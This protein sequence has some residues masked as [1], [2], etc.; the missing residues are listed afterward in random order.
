[1]SKNAH[2]NTTE[3]HRKIGKKNLAR[4][5]MKNVAKYISSVFGIRL[6]RKTIDATCFNKRRCFK[7]FERKCWNLSLPEEVTHMG[8][9]KYTFLFKKKLYKNN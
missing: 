8:S 4:C 1:M 9:V 6:T 5:D 7:N 3:T 2:D